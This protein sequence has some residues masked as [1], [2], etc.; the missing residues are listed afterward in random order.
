[1]SHFT[2]W[3][4]ED[5]QQEIDGP[6]TD[7]VGEDGLASNEAFVEDGDHWQDGDNWFGAGKDDASTWEAS[8]KAKVERQFT[9]VDLIG[10]ALDRVRDALLKNE[11]SIELAPVDETAEELTDEQARESDQILRELARWWDAKR[12]WPKL[13]EAVRRARWST[14]GTLRMWVPPGR[15]NNGALPT[16]LTFADAL[17]ILDITDPKPSEAA[18]IVDEETQ[19][20]V[21]VFLFTDDANQAQAE[22]WWAGNP[23]AERSETEGATYFR[24]LGGSS[25]EDADA[26]VTFIPG[27]GGHLPIA[28]MEGSLLITDAVR[29]QQNRLNHFESL[30]N[31][32]AETAGFPERY[33]VNA[34]PRGLWLTTPPSGAPAL[35]EKDYKGTTY[36]LHESSLDLGAGITVNLEG[37]DMPDSDGGERVAT[38]SVVFRDPT[39][40]EY[41]IKSAQHAKNS[42]LRQVKQ[43]HLINT[44]QAEASGTAYEQAR[45]D[46]ENDLAGTRVELES[47]LREF[48]TAAIAWAGAMSSEAAGILD[49]WRLVVQLNVNSGPLTAD[50]RSQT[51]SEWKDGLISRETALSKL[52]VDDV[53][54]ELDRLREEERAGLD[55]RSKQA[56]IITRLMVAIPELEPEAAVK[57]AGLDPEDPDDA[58]LIGLL[59]RAGPRP[60][61]A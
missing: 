57:F 53:P 8:T 22:L 36:Y 31:R 52:G 7:V 45:A 50:Q 42:L 6:L 39:D 27:T 60:R 59:Q 25:D 33:I 15:L 41:V 4:L 54:A 37:I 46:H 18:V 16:G 35:D 51:V 17:D 2:E 21:A 14:R 47:M 11:P 1:M 48:L 28:Q 61:A 12:L 56:E 26:A 30:L 55:L 44:S 32:S 13:G 49:K 40:P 5:V 34:K 23:D 29:R 19:E 24:R 43:G 38:P 58:E 9:P 20:R 3:K 10:E